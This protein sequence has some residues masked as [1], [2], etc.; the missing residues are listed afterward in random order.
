MA[1]RKT[2]LRGDGK[3]HPTDW[4]SVGG[5]ISSKAPHGG[6]RVTAV[7]VTAV[8]APVKNTG[9]GAWLFDNWIE[10]YGLRHTFGVMPGLDP[11]IHDESQQ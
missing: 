1:Q 9:S 4:L 3:S 5:G 8:Q 7:R 2:P 10:E 11:G 6:A